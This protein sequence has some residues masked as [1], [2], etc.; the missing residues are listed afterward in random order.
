MAGLDGNLVRPDIRDNYAAGLWIRIR[1]IP[2]RI[3]NPADD[4]LAHGRIQIF[5][6]ISV[7]NIGII[8]ISLEKMFK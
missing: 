5:C 4:N 8:F 1:A 6:Y 7:I 3:H 2:T